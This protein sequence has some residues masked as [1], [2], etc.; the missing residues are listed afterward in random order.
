V[1]IAALAEATDEPLGGAAKAAD[2]QA[3]LPAQLVQV[4]AA[5]VLELDALEQI[6]DA[7]VRI[8][9]RCVAGQPSQM[10]SSFPRTCRKSW[11]R[12]ATI[13]G[14]RNASVWTWVKRRPSGVMALMAAR[15]SRVSG[16]CSTG[17]R[18]RGAYVRATKGNR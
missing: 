7:F 13:A 10:T 2:G 6:P 17:A 16:V 4:L 14:P 15:W 18:P 11:R 12:K 3:E 9:V 8:E 1:N 5:A